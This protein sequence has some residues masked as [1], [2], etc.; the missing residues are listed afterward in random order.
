MITE[1]FILAELTKVIS[2]DQ[3]DPIHDLKRRLRCS[4]DWVRH[5][6]THP[7]KTTDIVHLPY[8]EDQTSFSDPAVDQLLI[9]V[10]T[11]FFAIRWVRISLSE[12]QNKYPVRPRPPQAGILMHSFWRLI[13]RGHDKSPPKAMREYKRAPQGLKD[14]LIKLSSELEKLYKKIFPDYQWSSKHTLTMAKRKSEQFS[15]S[16]DS[17]ASLP[18]GL[19]PFQN[20]VSGVLGFEGRLHR[21]TLSPGMLSPSLMMVI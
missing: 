21:R 20:S 10:G 19:L 2:L 8:I 3:S 13:C 5:Y 17:K 18:E 1:L 15:R 12:N 6:L 9:E 14:T 7:L 4:E 11:T 16:L